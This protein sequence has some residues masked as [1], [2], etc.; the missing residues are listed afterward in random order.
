MKKIY[1]FLHDNLISRKKKQF[2]LLSLPDES[3]VKRFGQ[4]MEEGGGD[5]QIG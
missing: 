5:P 1:Y 4:S 3:R 2:L